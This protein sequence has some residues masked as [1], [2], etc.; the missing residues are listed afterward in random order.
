MGQGG[1]LLPEVEML[2]GENH[3]ERVISTDEENR[4]LASASS[5]S[6]N[7]AFGPKH[8]RM[9]TKGTSTGTQARAA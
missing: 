8:T 3:R 5:Q 1:E 4:Y 2:S 9:A 7:P 6:T